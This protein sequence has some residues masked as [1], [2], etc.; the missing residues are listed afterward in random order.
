MNLYC[1]SID[2]F[3]YKSK[4]A[5]TVTSKDNKG[6]VAVMTF[7]FP[8]TFSAIKNNAD[9]LKLACTVVK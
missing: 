4:K 3:F 9:L 7:T 8:K 2:G 6:K 1:K 5:T